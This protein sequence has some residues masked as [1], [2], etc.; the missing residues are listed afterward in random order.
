MV[1][2]RV[3]FDLTET[4]GGEGGGKLGLEFGILES[5]GFFRGNLDEGLFAEMAHADD[6]ESMAPDGLLRLL[7]GG[8]AVRG[9]GES[10]GEPGGE[11]GRGGF[12]GNLEAGLA[13]EGPDVGFGQTGLA[14]RGGHRK[15][16]GGGAAGSDFAGVVE[17]FPIGEDRDT[18]EPG[19]FFHALE[20]LGAAEVATI[21][22]VGGI[23]G[24]VK[25]QGAEDFHR[26][27]MFLREREG[28]RMFRA[29][30]AGGVAEDAGDLGAEELVGGP[31]QEGGIDPA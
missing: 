28:S 9:D 6:A 12:F 8:E 11:A 27:A 15:F 4:G 24:V 3:E 29:R 13:G 18:P 25:F 21:G 17:V 19:Q 2:D 31:E 23:G 5:R 22:W 1:A 30:E 20:E 10:G 7:N 16:T 26:Q 14:E